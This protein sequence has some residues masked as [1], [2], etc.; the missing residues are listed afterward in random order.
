MKMQE[1]NALNIVKIK[2]SRL[3]NFGCYSS[4]NLNVII[5]TGLLVFLSFFFLSETISHYVP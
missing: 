5:A 2:L 1:K 3:L 4:G